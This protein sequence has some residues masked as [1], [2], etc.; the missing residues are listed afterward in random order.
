MSP[1]LAKRRVVS[2]DGI[3]HVDKPWTASVK[4]VSD[5]FVD[6]LH[7]AQLDGQWTIINALWDYRAD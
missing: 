6:Y 4:I 5:R 7:L 2:K 1:N 3:R